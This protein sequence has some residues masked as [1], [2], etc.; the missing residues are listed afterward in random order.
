MLLCLP[1]FAPTSL[2]AEVQSFAIVRG[3]EASEPTDQALVALAKTGDNSALSTLLM[4]HGP[5]V[6]RSVLLPRLG[7]EAAA[8]DALSETYAKVLTKMHL[9]AWQ[10]SG[11]YPWF[12]TVALHVALDHLRARKRFYVVKEETLEQEA[13]E[14]ASADV[15]LEEEQDRSRVRD[16][17]ETAMAKV[18]PRYAE[19]IK[20]RVLEERP[21]DDVAAALNVTPSTFDV[22]LHRAL[23]ALKK[24]LGDA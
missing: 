19:A 24:E 2:V 13:A 7:S 20:L 17:I 9:F 22:L 15:I 12:R 1:P 5:P 3:V 10:P 11:F 18:N 8:K 6:Y 16:R 14:G 23:A 4:R 21:R